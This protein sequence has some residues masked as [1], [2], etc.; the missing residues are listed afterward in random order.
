[1]K[2]LRIK[3]TSNYRA[4]LAFT[5]KQYL[6]EVLF[7]SDGYLDTSR[8]IEVQQGGNI[9]Q[10]NS[11]KITVADLLTASITLSKAKDINIYENCNN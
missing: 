2:T 7:F 10:F 5:G 8:T 9:Y 11:A 1:M 6:V 4:F 3:S